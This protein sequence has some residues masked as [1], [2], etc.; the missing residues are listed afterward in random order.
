MKTAAQLWVAV[1]I[2][3]LLGCIALG[4]Y[5]LCSVGDETFLGPARENLK[6][7]NLY[8]D[9]DNLRSLLLL[10]GFLP[11]ILAAWLGAGIIVDLALLR[12]LKEDGLTKEPQK[13][14][15]LVVL[16]LVFFVTV[17]GA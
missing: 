8:T 15:K 11:L 17:P 2:A 1:L 4:V 16:C 13:L 9:E 14:R 5:V 12:Y 10:A 3:A 7:Q 6:N